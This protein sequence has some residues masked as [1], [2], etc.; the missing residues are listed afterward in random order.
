MT[1]ARDRRLDWIGVA[2]FV[3]ALA[4]GCGDDSAGGS[5]G[6][7]GS[8]GGSGDSST[9]TAASMSTSA[10]TGD[11]TGA[12]SASASGD[13]SGGSSDG[14][15]SSG[16]PSEVQLSGDVRDFAQDI[17]IA[18]A[19]I[20]V[21]Q[22]PGLETTADA[23]GLW[24]TGPFAPNQDIVFLVEPSTDYWGAVIP[25]AVGASD[26][27]NVQLAQISQAFVQMQF[28]Q[29]V[30]QMPV[31]A[32]FGQ[33]VMIVRLISG[34][35]LMEGDVTVDMTPAPTPGTFYAPDVAGAPVL[36]S[37]LLQFSLLPVVVYYNLPDTEAGEITFDFSHPT[38]ECNTVFN[39]YP[40][41]G[42]FITLI[43]VEC[44]PPA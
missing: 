33:A 34:T 11:S 24:A 41:F 23:E 31:A 29:L 4:L 16:G 15:S 12:M 44:P 42:G 26:D 43:D 18:D 32:D 22:M 1:L 38:R 39:E 25:T 3:P 20:S 8:S 14:G 27:D 36:D 2:L 17:A 40:T 13:S 35:A 9:M 7:E 28:D 19:E 37:N 30:D 10:A 6:S 21:W 5:E